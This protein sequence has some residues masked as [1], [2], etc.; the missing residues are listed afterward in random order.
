M[1]GFDESWAKRQQEID[2]CDDDME[3]YQEHDI[4]VYS[5]DDEDDDEEEEEYDD[6]TDDDD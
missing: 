3:L 1:P 6:D 2:N 5:D 4:D